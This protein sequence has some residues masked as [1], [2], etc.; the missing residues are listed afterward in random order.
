[1]GKL[2]LLLLL[3]AAA[4]FAVAFLKKDKSVEKKAPSK[5]KVAVKKKAPSKNKSVKKI[6]VIDE[7][8]S[9]YDNE[10]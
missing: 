3:L 10:R 6:E 9:K 7:K 2:L 4:G 5:K 1:M 8:G